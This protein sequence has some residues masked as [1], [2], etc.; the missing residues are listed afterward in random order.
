MR[1]SFRTQ[2]YSRG[3]TG[4]NKLCPVIQRVNQSVKPATDKRV[5]QR[6]DRE[7]LLSTEFV[8]QSQLPKQQKQVHFGD[9]QL[10]VLTCWSWLPA[11]QTLSIFLIVRMGC[12]SKDAYFAY[13]IS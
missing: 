6:A 1:S 11:K 5:V 2:A 10:N 3:S 8:A 13:P 9:T 7:E 12:G 4:K